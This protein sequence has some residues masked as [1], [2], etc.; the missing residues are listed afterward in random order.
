MYRGLSYGSGVELVLHRQ[1]EHLERHLPKE[2]VVSVLQEIDGLPVRPVDRVQ[3]ALLEPHQFRPEEVR[4]Q[5][6]GVEGRPPGP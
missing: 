4:D 5:G 6:C 1:S 2:V 3:E